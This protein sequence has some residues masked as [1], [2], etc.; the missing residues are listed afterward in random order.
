MAEDETL[1]AYS[2]NEEPLVYNSWQACE[3]ISWFVWS[4]TL[5][6]LKKLKQFSQ[7]NHE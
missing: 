3:R 6:R 2:M 7:E 5:F 4:G 1:I